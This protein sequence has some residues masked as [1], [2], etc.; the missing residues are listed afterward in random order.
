[1]QHNPIALQSQ[2]I[3]LCFDI[4][5]SKAN[6]LIQTFRQVAL[7][8]FSYVWFLISY[9]GKR[10]RKQCQQSTQLFLKETRV[11]LYPLHLNLNNACTTAPLIWNEYYLFVNVETNANICAPV[12]VSVELRSLCR[13]TWLWRYENK[14]ALKEQNLIT[15]KGSYYNN[16]NR[17]RIISHQSVLSPLGKSNDIV[18]TV[19]VA[20]KNSGYT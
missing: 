4:C 5:Y 12:S 9:A 10:R 8:L 1:M 13:C 7:T 15:L 18:W 14:T 19:K 11:I 2:A 17:C 16:M 3:S 6:E 20:I